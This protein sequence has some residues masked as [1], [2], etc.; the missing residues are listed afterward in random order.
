MRY[1]I[2]LQLVTLTTLF[3]L[4]AAAVFAWVQNRP[5]TAESSDDTLSHSLTAVLLA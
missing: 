2:M 1:S 3:L 5:T 4:G